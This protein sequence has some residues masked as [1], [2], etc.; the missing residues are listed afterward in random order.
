LRA[1]C[2]RLADLIDQCV[3]EQRDFLPHPVPQPRDLPMLMTETDVRD[4][5]RA[6]LAGGQQPSVLRIK[7]LFIDA[8]QHPLQAT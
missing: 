5:Y 3:V 8:G 4:A 6:W 2:D 7:Q 1:G